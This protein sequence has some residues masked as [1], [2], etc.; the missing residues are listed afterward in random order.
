MYIQNKSE[1]GI[2]ILMC[3]C[4]ILYQSTNIATKTLEEEKEQK[5]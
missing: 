4:C 5:K 3:E 2:D 1:N